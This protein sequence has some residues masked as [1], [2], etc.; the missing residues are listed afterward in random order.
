MKEVSLLVVTPQREELAPL[1]EGVRGRGH[2]IRALSVGRIDT[3]LVSSL[4]A[5]FAV[6][7]H[8]KTQLG[9]QTQ[10]LIDNCPG[11]DTVVCAGAAGAL[12]EDVRA[13]DIVVSTATIEHDYRLR[14]VKAALPRWET[15]E[16]TLVALRAAA[17][18]LRDLPVR[19]GPVASGDEDVIE[20]ARAAELARTTGALCVAWEGAGGARAARFNELRFVE[21]RGITDA[22]NV[23]A[24]VSYRMNL[25]PVMSRIGQLIA[26][27][28]SAPI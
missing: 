17:G 28:R 23:F 25:K 1:I 22:A 15:D 4:R 19:F 5:L 21:I 13:G 10:H 2:E 20:R 9:L 8:G 3:L 12:A 18:W 14:F 11:L 27:W 26:Y 7:G 6:A 16:E 24:R